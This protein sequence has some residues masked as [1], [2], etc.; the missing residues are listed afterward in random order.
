MPF[1][2]IYKGSE[3]I[4]PLLTDEEW[5]RLKQEI[6]ASNDS[7]IIAA[8]GKEGYLRKSSR[9]LKHLAH[10]KGEAPLNWKPESWEHLMA[11][12]IFLKA[13]I[14]AGWNASPEYIG[15]GWVA[16]V[17]AWKRN[18]KIAFE[19]QWSGQTLS[20]TQERQEKYL[21]DN[22]RGCWFFKRLPV[23]PDS[24]INLWQGSKEI[25]AFKVEIDDNENM[26]IEFENNK[27]LLYDFVKMLL[28]GGLT[29]SESISPTKDKVIRLDYN[30]YEQPCYRC[31]RMYYRY[32][33]NNSFY[34]GE[35]YAS[36]KTVSACN[37]TV[38]LNEVLNEE[39]RY[40]FEQDIYNEAISICEENGFLLAK[41]Q[42]HYNR[43]LGKFHFVFCCPSCKAWIDDYH[44]EQNELKA[45]NLLRFQRKIIIDSLANVKVDCP[46][47]CYS[48]FH[49]D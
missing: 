6:K 12:E 19:I 37:R 7:L 23:D 25:P 31:N 47:W 8:T 30:F 39:K 4:A 33:V 24:D 18:V 26:Y 1:K 11:K 32:W 38:Q 17:L 42:K 45:Q 16:D 28:N 21:K 29:F 9:G 40:R 5:D 41:I 34:D 13:S 35:H 49:E 20:V 10:K 36:S 22:V 15:H 14:D 44:L 46:H 2:G 43:K 27:I 3:I 48:K